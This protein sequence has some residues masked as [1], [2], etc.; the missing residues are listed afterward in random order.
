MSLIDIYAYAYMFD[1]FHLMNYN[2]PKTCC[3]TI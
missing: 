3:T 1:R 2:Y